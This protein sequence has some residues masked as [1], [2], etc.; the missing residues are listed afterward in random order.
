MPHARINQRLEVIKEARE[1]IGGI[2]FIKSQT[3]N[4]LIIDN[5]NQKKESIIF[6][7]EIQLDLIDAQQV[8]TPEGYIKEL[9]NE[10]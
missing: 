4:H 6:D 8:Y 1:A 3:E 10:E 5:L 7:L 2:N 9:R